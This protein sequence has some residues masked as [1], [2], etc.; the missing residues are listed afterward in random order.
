M[1][2]EEAFHLLTGNT[3]LMRIVKAGQIPTTIMQK[4]FNKW[5]STAHDLFGQ[6]H[7]ATAHWGYLWGVK[8]RYD[9]HL[10][11]GPPDMGEINAISRGQYH[12]EVQAIIDSLNRNVKPEQP[13]LFIP[14]EKFNR[15][16]GDF[17]G[18]TYTVAGETIEPEKY[19][20]YLKEVFPSPED[21]QF[22]IG[23]E[24]EKGWIINPE[25][26]QRPR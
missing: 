17:A 4:Y 14:D 5:L 1:L 20:A 19:E 6:D 2:Q 16:I 24:K 15:S 11:D 23:L 10:F 12:K 9:E 21:E 7:S 26:P 3:G 13:K 22:I 25:Q 18:K 8:G